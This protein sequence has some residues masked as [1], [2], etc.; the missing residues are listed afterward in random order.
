MHAAWAAKQREET[1]SLGDAVIGMP[2]ANALYALAV[3]GECSWMLAMKSVPD[4]LWVTTAMSSSRCAFQPS[5]F[6]ENL[7][8]FRGLPWCAG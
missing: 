4:M 6:N 5:R 1:P 2:V 8:R 7:D 3:V